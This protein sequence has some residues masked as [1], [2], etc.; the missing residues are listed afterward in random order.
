MV[1]ITQ[2]YFVIKLCP[3]SLSIFLGFFCK[4]TVRLRQPVAEVLEKFDYIVFSYF[5]PTLGIP[6]ANILRNLESN[7]LLNEKLQKY[8][9]IFGIT[10]NNIYFCNIKTKVYG[11]KKNHRDRFDSSPWLLLRYLPIFGR[12][13]FWFDSLIVI[14]IV[15]QIYNILN[16]W[17]NYL[18]TLCK[19]YRRFCLKASVTF[20]R[21][22]LV[23]CV[24][25]MNPVWGM[26][27]HADFFRE[28]Y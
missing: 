10:N 24:V 27:T 9:R 28:I 16:R 8:A 22:S 12:S 1:S 7:T 6:W 19:P 15:L 2:T 25:S 20:T 21:K 18:S 26:S 23:Y 5:C 14:W 4:S 11:R 3:L 17:P 13:P